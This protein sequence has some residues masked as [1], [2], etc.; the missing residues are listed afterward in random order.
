MA[1][2]PPRSK[3]NGSAGEKPG[4]RGCFAYRGCRQHLPSLASP[5]SAGR[6]RHRSEPGSAKRWQVEPRGR[7]GTG[8][9]SP[10][11]PLPVPTSLPRAPVPPC[12]GAQRRSQPQAV[13]AAAP[14]P[15][16]RAR[17]AGALLPSWRGN[18]NPPG[19]KRQAR[20]CS[21][22]GATRAMPDS[23][24][25]P[26]AAAA[27]PPGP[28]WRPRHPAPTQHRGTAP[29]PSALAVLQHPSP[30]AHLLSADASKSRSRRWA[31]ELRLVPSQTEGVA[32]AVPCSA[33]KSPP[34]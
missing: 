26:R 31:S 19:E 33:F 10:H 34:P 17:G 2:P 12:I 22:N 7:F 9:T 6:T 18:Q 4:P 21:P 11:A 27:T 8:R 25:R 28:G 15:A 29:S 24:A 1:Q 13:P 5:G 14:A 16:R 32:G 3:G 20:I 23:S 30:F